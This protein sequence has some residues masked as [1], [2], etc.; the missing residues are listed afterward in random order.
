MASRDEWFAIHTAGSGEGSL[1]KSAGP[2][3]LAGGFSVDWEAAPAI[4]AAF[5][6]AIQEMYEARK[7]MRDMQY[8]RNA[9][10]NPVVDK[11]LAALVEVG[12]GDQSSV[13]MVANSAVA[14]YQSVI[15]QLDRVMADYKE[16]DASGKGQ[17]EQQS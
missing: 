10:V 9:G 16:G 14:E 1:T 6:E 4:R 15:E 8:V 7:A 3:R 12:Y 13:T 11:Y 5:E 2:R 17:L